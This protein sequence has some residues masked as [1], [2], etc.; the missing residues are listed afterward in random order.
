MIRGET[1]MRSIPAALTWELFQRGKW[2]LLGAFLTGN[3]LTFVL[4]TVM[5][6]E[7]IDLQDRSMIP[8]HTTMLLV[9]AMTFG[10]VLLSAMGNPYRLRA[11]PA[12]TSAIVA[13]QLL[14]AM[15]AMA[16]ECL[17]F[18]AVVN[19]VFKVNWPLWGPALF[20]PVALA[21]FAAMFWLTEKSPWHFFILAL[22]VLSGVMMWY[23]SRYGVPATRMWREVT[24]AEIATML[25]MA[26]VFYYAATVGVA[27][28]RCGEYLQTPEFLRWLGRLLDPA[29]DVGLPFRTPAQAQFWFEW[30]QKGWILPFIVVSSLLV[31][32]VGWLL[33]NRN[34]RDLLQ[35]ATTAGAFLPFAGLVV[36]LVFGNVNTIEGKLEMGHFLSTRAM[37]SSDMSRTTLKAAGMS[38]LVAWAIWIAAFLGL[39]A[40]L[41]L[42][43]VGPH[44]LLN[45]QLPGE[46]GWWYFPLTLLGTWLALTFVATI[47]Q[48]GRPILLGALFCGVPSMTMVVALFSHFVLTPEGRTMLDQGIATLVGLVFILGTVWAVAAARRRLAIGSRTVWAA[49]GAWAALC[50]LSTVFWLQHR[51]EHPASLPFSVLVIGVIALVAFPLAASPLAVAWNRNR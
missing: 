10:A 11:F 38:V 26:G 7:G 20:M 35:G 19:A 16:V 23:A 15:T 31:G 39:Y 3:A 28:S 22:P 51:G 49:I 25:A 41:F 45:K 8:M 34:P 17:L 13:W 2:N 21:A 27:R 5:L 47:G 14:P 42:A 9:N 36:G 6:R 4:L 43:N 32:F 46:A 18:T 30:R 50:A 24:P 37:A 29:P 48:T 1:I 12:P 44:E 40:I 33:F